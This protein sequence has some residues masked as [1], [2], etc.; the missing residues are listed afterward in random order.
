MDMAEVYAILSA[1]KIR[2]NHLLLQLVAQESLV[3]GDE[4]LV[5]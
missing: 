1:T 5:Q 2:M 3:L 4:S